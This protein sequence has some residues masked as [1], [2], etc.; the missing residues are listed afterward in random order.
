LDGKQSKTNL[1]YRPPLTRKSI[2]MVY[3]IEFKPRAIRDLEAIDHT[4]ARRIIEKIRLMQDELA[5]M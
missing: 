1:D 2:I 5:E 3:Q 4:Q